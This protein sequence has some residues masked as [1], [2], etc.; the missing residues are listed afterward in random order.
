VVSAIQAGMMYRNKYSK[1]R[2]TW[3]LLVLTTIALGACSTSSLTKKQ[4]EAMERY[5][6][7]TADAIHF[8]ASKVKTLLSDYKTKNGT[9]PKEEKDRRAIFYD[10]DSVLKEHHI[11]DQKLVEVDSNEIIVEYSFSNKKFK[12]FPHILESWVIIFSNEKK[13]DLEIVSVFP[14][15]CDID[16]SAKMTSYSAAQIEVLRERFQK[17]LQ[18]ELTNYS[19]SLS[20]HIDTS[21]TEEPPG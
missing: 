3:M 2:S 15:W 13:D 20:E 10:I 21:N 1:R 14:H 7:R 4:R 16:K 17:L 6:D 5:V 8:S 11:E 19:I 18:D 12:Q 9:W